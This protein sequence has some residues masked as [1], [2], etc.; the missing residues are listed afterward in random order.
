ME[1]AGLYAVVMAGGKGERFW[2]QSR[3]SHPKQ[4]LRLIGNLT[5]IEQTVDRLFP[6]IAPERVIVVTNEEYVAP[7]RSLLSNLPPKNIIGEPAGRDTAPCLTIAAAVIREISGS[8]NSVMIA[9]PADH[10]IRKKEEFQQNL[11]DSADMAAKS[12]KI[13]TIGV[14]PTFPSTGYGYIRCGDKPQSLGKTLFY[15]SLGFKEKPNSALAEKFAADKAY[16][17]NSGI[18][19]WTLSAFFKALDKY[20]PELGKMAKNIQ[21][22]CKE[23]K[24]AAGME[25]EYKNCPRISVDY[26]VM[27]KADN[28]AVAESSFDW[29][30]VGS[31]TALRNQIRADADNNVIRGLHES[32]DTKNCIVVS[33]P[34][35]LVATVDVDNLIIVHTDDAT[36]VCSSRSAQK[37]KDLVKEISTRPELSRFL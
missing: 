5:L 27:E 1:T 6:L 8:E 19:V 15:D 28:V 20:A 7:M 21:K 16:R 29:D 18:F 9:L 11:R 10:I 36:L 25:A 4:L 37:I 30:D 3:N 26:A 12:G 32:I 14:N 31:W 2:P 23:D 34:K 33:D 17:W 22:A 13:L 24:L 35:H